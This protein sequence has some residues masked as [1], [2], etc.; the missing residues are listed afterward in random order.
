MFEESAQDL[1]DKGADP[2]EINALRKA[3]KA[4]EYEVWE[5]NWE[6]VEMFL[7]MQTQWN[8]S[9]GGPSGFNYSSLDYLCRL[10][11]VEDPVTLFEGLQVM[12][13]AA[14]A[15]LNKRSN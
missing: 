5:E 1:I 2:G 12:E 4:A 11:K 6:T 14:L 3:A 7:R 8:M 15:S 13:Y 9:M 10:Y